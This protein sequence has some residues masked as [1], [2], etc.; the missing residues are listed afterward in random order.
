M[1]EELAA[2][3]VARCDEEEAAAMAATGTAWA[4]EAT[5]EKDNSWAVGHVESEDGRPLSG[6]IEKGQGVVIDG[7]CESINGHLADAGH[8]ARHDPARVLRDVAAD[9]LLL[10]TVASWRRPGRR[11]RTSSRQGGPRGISG[12]ASLNSPDGARWRYR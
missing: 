2:F 8:I 10:A 4:W 5:G 12:S 1:D 3:A 7:V 6:Q 11:R 9:R